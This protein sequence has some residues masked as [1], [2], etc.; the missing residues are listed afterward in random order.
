[1]I[2]GQGGDGGRKE[3]RLRMGREQFWQQRP[4]RTLTPLLGLHLPLWVR[5]QHFV[6]TGFEIIWVFVLGISVT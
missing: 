5:F 2:W 1:M 3:G 6:D 4:K